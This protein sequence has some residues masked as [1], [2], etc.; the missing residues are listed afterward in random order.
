MVSGKHKGLVFVGKSRQNLMETNEVGGLVVKTAEMGERKDWHRQ[1][2]YKVEIKGVP[3]VAQWIKNLT[4]IH[5]D[6]GSLSGLR[7]QRCR[8]MRCKV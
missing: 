2:A 6:V 1:T 7:I 3:V 4:S 8:K 5:E